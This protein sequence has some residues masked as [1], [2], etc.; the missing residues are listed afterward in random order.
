MHGMDFPH[1]FISL[2]LLGLQ[3]C[4]QAVSCCSEQGL[5]SSCGGFSSCGTQVQ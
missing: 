3:H 1:L 2:A 4:V 5:L